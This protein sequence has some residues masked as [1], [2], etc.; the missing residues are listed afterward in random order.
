MPGHEAV[1]A[2]LV[3]L[4]KA[5]PERQYVLARVHEE[6]ERNQELMLYLERQGFLPGAQVILLE[7]TAVNETVSLH[8]DGHP[9]VLGLAVARQLWLQDN[10][11]EAQ[12]ANQAQPYV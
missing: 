9:V 7:I 10:M 4:L 5:E 3:P 11:E 8:C 12:D 2:N 1:T 6:V